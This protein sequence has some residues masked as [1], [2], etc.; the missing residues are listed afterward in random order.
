[1]NKKKKEA[2]EQEAFEK[3]YKKLHEKTY[4]E[5]FKNA[6]D[7]DEKFLRDYLIGEWWKAKDTSSLP[8]YKEI[9][10]EEPPEHG[11]ISD[12]EKELDKEDEFEAKY[13]FRFEEE[14]ANEI[15]SFPRNIPGSARQ[16]KQKLKNQKRRED[17]QKRKEQEKKVKMQELNK[18]KNLKQQEILE[19][20]K[21]IEQ[22]TGTKAE[23]LENLNLDQ[24][25]DP[26]EY[27]KR[28]QDMFNEDFYNQD[29]DE[30][31]LK[32][33]LA[34]DEDLDMLLAEDFGSKKNAG[35]KPL[36]FKT[37]LEDKIKKAEKKKRK[38]K[39]ERKR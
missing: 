24:D 39:E 15:L 38:K 5:V 8:T 21:Q 9:I 6:V 4:T 3:N 10:G 31:S 29:E 32:A 16:D 17:R 20:L 28:M 7:D 33:A 27:D 36:K 23:G 34:G 11:D 30:E 22:I 37:E 2:K 1:V 19:K 35:F 18:L 14:G 26:D 25:F 13:N 12:E